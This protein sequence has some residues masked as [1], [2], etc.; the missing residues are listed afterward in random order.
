MKQIATIFELVKFEHT[1]FALPFAYLGSWLAA[2]GPPHPEKGALIL[3]AMVG[4]RTAAMAFNR[5]AD[6]K[7]DALN[8]RTA[9]RPIP[10]GRLSPAAAWIVCLAAAAAFFWPVGHLTVWPSPFRPWPWG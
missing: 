3:G 9:G 5:I 10:S 4:A 6:A 2:S 8:P 1:I 7:I